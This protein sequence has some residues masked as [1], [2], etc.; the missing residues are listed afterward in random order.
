MRVLFLNP[1]YS[2]YAGLK[3]HGGVSAP[4]NLAYIAAYVREQEPGYAISIL[5]AE[6]LELSHEETLDQV[7]AFQ[8]DII[9]ITT[10]TPSPPPNHES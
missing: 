2:R 8:P 1:S 7:V 5:D 6:A 10:T 3:G 4:L 9:G